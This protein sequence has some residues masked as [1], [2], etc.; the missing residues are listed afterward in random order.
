MPKLSDAHIDAALSAL[1][2]WERSENAPAIEKTYEF[3]T[4]GQAMTWVNRV[5]AM[6]EEADHHP[7][8]DIRYLQVKLALSTHSQG[9]ITEKDVLLAERIDELPRG[10]DE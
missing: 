8:I 1:R 7:D 5:A 3:R 2:G 4:F 6:A 9:G 10:E